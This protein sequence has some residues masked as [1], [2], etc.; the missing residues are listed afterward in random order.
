[1]IINNILSDFRMLIRTSDG[2]IIDIKMTN[3]I[4]DKEY[5]QVLYSIS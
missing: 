4:T 3:F 2:K 5:Y 1:M